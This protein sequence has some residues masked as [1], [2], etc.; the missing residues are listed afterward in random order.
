MSTNPSSALSDVQDARIVE[1]RVGLRRVHGQ[2]DAGAGRR[3]RAV[4]YLRFSTEEQHLGPEAQRTAIESCEKASGFE[5]SS[6]G[7]RTWGQR[8]SRARRPPGSSCGPWVTSRPTAPP[9]DGDLAGPRSRDVLNAGAIEAAAS[10]RGARAVSAEPRSGR[11]GAH[12]RLAAAAGRL[13]RSVRARDDSRGRGR[14]RAV[15]LTSEELELGDHLAE[16]PS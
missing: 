16:G 9:P 5:R 15:G 1:R 7:G 10:G 8:G 4:T 3:R 11:G 14:P 2:A 6:P 12:D 13:L